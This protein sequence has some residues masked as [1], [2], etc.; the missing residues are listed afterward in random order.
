MER[1]SSD[2]SRIELAV[3]EGGLHYLEQRRQALL[4]HI[5][6]LDRQMVKQRDKIAALKR[7]SDFAR[8]SE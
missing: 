4:E 3:H 2:R 8:Q 5:K 6:I 7:R 1:R